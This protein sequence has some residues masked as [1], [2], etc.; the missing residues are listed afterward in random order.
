MRVNRPII[1]Q[2]A[3][4]GT[5]PAG[6]GTSGTTYS[7]DDDRVIPRGPRLAAHSA[8]E[9][10]VREGDPEPLVKPGAGVPGLQW[11]GGAII[12]GAVLFAGAPGT[13]LFLVGDV[14][15]LVGFGYP[16]VRMLRMSDAEWEH[17]PADWRGDGVRAAVERQA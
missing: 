15:H 10:P 17:P 7:A 13:V 1:A 5:G 3:D 2:A 14:L 4:T 6:A 11:A 8:A 9:S 12:V 16:G